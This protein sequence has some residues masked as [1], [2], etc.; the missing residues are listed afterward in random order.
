MVKV[1]KPVDGEDVKLNLILNSDSSVARQLSINIAVQSMK[2]TGQPAGNI[3]TKAIEEQLLPGRSNSLSRNILFRR[4]CRF[5]EIF[6]WILKCWKTTVYPI[7]SFL[8]P[9]DLTIPILVPFL[10]YHKHMIGCDSMNISAVITDQ[11]KKNHMFLAETRIVL[12]NPPIT[13]TVSTN[14]FNCI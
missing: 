8:F 12:M 6:F 11:R 4:L 9:P 13:I 2:Y 14:V 1:S 10:T 3:L 7:L 5:F